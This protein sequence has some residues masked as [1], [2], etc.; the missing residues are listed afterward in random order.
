MHVAAHLRP[1]HP[2]VRLDLHHGGFRNGRVDF[3][4]DLTCVILLTLIHKISENKLNMIPLMNKWTF[5]DSLVE[6]CS[7]FSTYILWNNGSGLV[8]LGN[9][10]FDLLFSLLFQL[11]LLTF[12]FLFIRFP[13][14]LARLLAIAS[15]F[16]W[17]ALLR[18]WRGSWLR[19]SRSFL[20]FFC[21]LLLLLLL[22][23]S[24]LLCGVWSISC[25]SLRWKIFSSHVRLWN[26]HRQWGRIVI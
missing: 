13:L 22:V 21:V 2:F 25:I 26:Q 8:R 18:T 15:S 7:I 9:P 20:C 6:M 19:F 1:W 24:V 11:L 12:L 10:F 17:T 14:F 16:P 4:E 3:A 5:H 23:L